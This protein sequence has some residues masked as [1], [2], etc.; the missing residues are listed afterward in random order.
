MMDDEYSHGK[1]INNFDQSEKDGIN[2]CHCGNE[3]IF[4]RT[5][6]IYESKFDT[7]YGVDC[8]GNG[9][10]RIIKYNEYF[11]HFKN[12]CTDLCEDYNF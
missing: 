11:Y 2:C 6:G 5:C 9:C 10:D 12:R 8:C 4:G 7:K 3:F 1:N